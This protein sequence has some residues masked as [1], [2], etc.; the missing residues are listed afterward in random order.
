[1]VQVF[2]GPHMHGCDINYIKLCTCSTENT[3]IRVL[4]P[5]TLMVKWPFRSSA[6]LTSSTKRRHWIS[7]GKGRD[8]SMGA[9]SA[10]H[11]L[12]PLPQMVGK[13]ITT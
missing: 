8:H 2:W 4:A 13:L 5:T 3:T 7:D 11:Q 6:S 10:R 9:P 1:M 12:I